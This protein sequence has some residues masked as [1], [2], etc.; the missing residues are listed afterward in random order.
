MSAIVKTPV[1][2]KKQ[3]NRSLSGRK[4]PLKTIRNVLTSSRAIHWPIISQEE[5]NKITGVL[6]CITDSI[7][8]IQNGASKGN[9][10][11][12]TKI[13]KKSKTRGLAKFGINEVSKCL[14]KDE[15]AAVLLDSS[16][17]HV[18]ITH[19]LTMATTKQVPL[20]CIKH[21]NDVTKLCFEVSSSSICFTGQSEVKFPSIVKIIHEIWHK[22]YRLY[23][24]DPND[25]CSVNIIT[26]SIKDVPENSPTNDTDPRPAEDYIKLQTAETAHVTQSNRKRKRNPTFQPL[27]I[28]RIQNNPN[29]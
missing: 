3:Q 8:S 2:S 15:C 13:P 26:E 21:L 11:D 4:K 28:K 22:N 5:G 14:M 27:L 17:P 10:N 25:Q 7:I 20:L 23:E 24:K 6:K 9:S 19:I 1:L 16:I 12:K 29:R 18:M